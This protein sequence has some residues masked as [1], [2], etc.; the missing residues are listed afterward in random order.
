MKKVCSNCNCKTLNKTSRAMIQFDYE[1]AVVY[2]NA[3]GV[4]IKWKSDNGIKV[5]Y[6]KRIFDLVKR[7]FATP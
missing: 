7:H 4:E 6:N 3:K 5:E 2:F 1:K